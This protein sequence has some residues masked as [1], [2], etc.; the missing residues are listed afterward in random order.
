MPTASTKGIEKKTGA[1]I[2]VFL[3]QGLLILITTI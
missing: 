3:D 2:Y 1:H